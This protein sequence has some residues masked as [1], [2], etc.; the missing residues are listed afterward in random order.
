VDQDTA[1]VEVDDLIV[2]ILGAPGGLPAHEGRIDG[3][4]RLEKLVF[5]LEQ[6]SS[7][8][9]LLSESPDFKPY[10]FGPFSAK[11]YAAIDT[12]VLAGLWESEAVVGI[13]P[14]D[15]YATRNVSLTQRGQRYYKALIR[16]LPAGTEQELKSFKDRFASVP[17]RQLVRYVYQRYPAMTER[18]VIRDDILGR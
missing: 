13:E 4:T 6:E 11:V 2:L 18:S 3:I 10:N 9:K 12:L 16:D 17:L 8:G 1:P 7:L 15:A 5:L 14:S